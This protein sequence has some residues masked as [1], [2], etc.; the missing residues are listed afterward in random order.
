MHFGEH[1]L[2]TYN[3]ILGLS[4]GGHLDP[5]IHQSNIFFKGKF[6]EVN[7]ADLTIP[8]TSLVARFSETL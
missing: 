4:I 3:G 2:P 7:N 6:F 1:A 8:C 5:E